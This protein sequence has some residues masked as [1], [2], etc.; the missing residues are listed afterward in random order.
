MVE[1]ASPLLRG[2][3][4]AVI[5]SR[6]TDVCSNVEFVLVDFVL[7]GLSLIKL[8]H[9]VLFSRLRG[10][11]FT[12]CWSTTNIS[13]LYEGIRIASFKHFGRFGVGCLAVSVVTL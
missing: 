7:S 1:K 11:E 8:K 2:G 4:E 10:L 3:F 9:H 13:A 12:T 5:D 6:R